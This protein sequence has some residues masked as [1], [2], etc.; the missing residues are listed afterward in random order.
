MLHFCHLR[1]FGPAI[2]S[3]FW[4]HWETA[5]L[6]QILARSLLEANFCHLR[7]FGPAIKSAF[8]DHWEMADLGQILARSFMEANFWPLAAPRPA[9]KIPSVIIGK[10]PF[11]VKS[12]PGAFWKQISAI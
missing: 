5:V 2:K 12:W 7:A 1:A 10:R 6:G 8:W 3:A 11:W 4:D 9:I